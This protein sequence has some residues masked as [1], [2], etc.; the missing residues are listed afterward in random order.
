MSIHVALH[1][2]SVY[3]FDRPVTLSPHEIRLRPAAHA[4]TPVLSYSLHI[5]PAKHFLNWQQD[6]YGN[7]VAR[8]VFPDLTRELAVTVDLVADMTVI[9][10]FDFFVENYAERY[11]FRY[12]DSLAKELAPFLETAES[13]SRLTRWLQEFRTAAVRDGTHINDFLVAVNQRV[14]H[15][16]AYLLRMQPG[17]QSCEQTLAVGSGSCRDSAWLMVNVL[18]HLGIA[19]RFV[20]GYLIQLVAD[21]KSLDGPAGPQADFTDLHAWAE[22]Y[23]PGAGWIGLDPTS[24]LLTGEGHIPLACTA[25]PGSAAPIIGMTDVC[26]A[27]FDVSMTVARLREDPRVTRPYSIDQWNAIIALGHAVDA[28]LQSGDVRLTQ[29]GEPTFVSIDDMDGDE[30]SFTALSPAKLKLARALRR[31]LQRRFAPGALLHSSQG[32]WYP[33]EPLPRWSLGVYWRVDGKPIWSDPSLIV[34]D[35]ADNGQAVCTDADGLRFA[36]RL[37]ERLGFNPQYL[38]P[39]YEDVRRAVAEEDALPV[40]IDP[41][42]EDLNALTGRTRLARLLRRGLG[43]VAGY[44]LPLRAA[45][46]KTTKADGREDRPDW[47]SSRWPLKSEHLY[48]IPGDSPAGFRLPLDALPE[49]D[50]ADV[51]TEQPRDP[52][53][54]RPPLA[55]FAA[56]AEDVP[57]RTDPPPLNPAPKDVVRTALCVEVRDGQLHV[58]MS[59]LPYIEDYL[60]LVT[61]LE[62]TARELQLP[63]AIEGYP[64]PADARVK[65]LNITPDPGVI[66]V[67]I[68]PAQSWDELV[69]NTTILYEEARFSRLAAEKF[70]LDGRH[71]GTG[72][73]NHVT[74]GGATVMDSPLLRRPDL[75]QSLVTYWQNHPA[76]SY[77]FSG[78]FVGPTSQAPRVD[79]ARD[80]NL[81]ELEIAFQQMAEKTAT[82]VESETPWLVDRLLRN[83]LVDLTGNTHRAEFCIDKLYAPTG[84]NGRLGLLEFRAFEMP[85]HAQMSLTEMLLLR[86]LLV[87]FWNKPYAGKLVHWGTQLHDRFMLPHFLVQDLNDIVRELNAAGYAFQPEWFLPFLEFRFPRYGSVVYAGIQLELRQAIEPWNVL[88][89]DMQAGS[90]ARYVDSSVERLQVKVSGMADT[91]HVATC[92]GRALPLQPTGVQGEF[93][94]GVRYRAWDPPSALHPTIAPHAPLTFDIVDTWSG[95]AIGGCTYH[96]SH[97]G[98][99]SYE[100]FP[101][102]ANEAEARRGARFWPHGHTPGTVTVAAEAANRNFPF[103]LDLRRSA[104]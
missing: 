20:S 67:N 103:T 59:P 93:V 21:I 46:R 85:P 14:Q 11:P 57:V 47:R 63:V 19:A 81:Y 22:A 104:A 23:I 44:V 1:H 64:P 72:G 94:A 6:V 10:P 29:G 2:R 86:A 71:T 12:P 95:R 66:E 24:G 5:A 32:K 31:R 4:R 26:E 13:G 7:Y 62:K 88:G 53:D 25:V 56:M 89:E 100:T 34:D 99:R 101:V 39:A 42:A 102:N 27:T 76:L 90:T 16:I 58:F 96:V 17:V 74:L 33:G 92:N 28:Q 40:N 18:R 87:R 82:G 55:D 30:W 77:F 37:A 8:A 38:I 75:L 50:P 91:R 69:A 43:S 51:E 73:G 9:N 79:E 84:P 78:M 65:V 48:L 61:A 49:V 68:H 52:F 41:L 70:M 35:V 3:R 98:G 80:D 60:A 45:V 83:L 36:T 97:P 15:D 54:A